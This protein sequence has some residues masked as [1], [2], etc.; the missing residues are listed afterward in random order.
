MTICAFIA[1]VGELRETNTR[2]IVRDIALIDGTGRATATLWDA[3]ATRF[4]GEE[5]SLVELAALRS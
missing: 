4:S 1:N 3:L 5:G 2:G